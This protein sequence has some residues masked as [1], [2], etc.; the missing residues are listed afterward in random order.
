MIGAIVTSGYVEGLAKNAPPGAPERL[1]SALQNSQALVSYR[2][3]EALD[4]I[5]SSFPGGEQVVSEMVQS[6]RQTLSGSIQDGFIFALAAVG[7]AIPAAL[8][9]EDIHLGKS[10]E[11][12]HERPQRTFSRE[13]HRNER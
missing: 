3:R 12:V 8:L 7:L 4:R 10:P 9:M 11:A 1:V 6:A 2:A 13:E 5:A